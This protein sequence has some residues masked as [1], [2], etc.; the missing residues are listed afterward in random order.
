M[1]AYWV[2]IIAGGAV[3]R[4]VEAWRALAARAIES[5]L[6]FEPA[7]ALPALRLEP[8]RRTEFFLLWRAGAPPRLVLLW[9]MAAR[10]AAFW[11]QGWRHDYLCVGAPLLDRDEAEAALDAFLA[12]WAARPS[13]A[14]LIMGPLWPQGGF[15]R[16]LSVAAAQRGQGMSW[17]TREKRALL[18]LRKPPQP[19]SAKR[20]KEWARLRRRLDEK[21]PL[22]M[23]IDAETEEIAC[24][25]DQFLELEACG[26]KGRDGGALARRRG[27]A[28]FLREM[29][30]ALAREQNC[31]LFRLTSGE[32]TLACHILLGDTR[33]GYFW[34]TAYDEAF[35]KFSPG[36]LLTLDMTAELHRDSWRSSIDSCARPDHSMI[37]KLWLDRRRFGEIALATRPGSGFFLRALIFYQQWRRI[38]RER[39]KAMA[40][41]CFRRGKRSSF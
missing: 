2:E 36:V 6:F 17:I 4:H 26:W 13:L 20:R 22:R 27:H 19:A 29:G 30:M 18:D 28:A 39:A 1:A 8:N 38:L 21:S 3:E 14:A 31:R 16:A 41:Q 35:E 37:D 24:G 32:R 5:N 10:R 33:Q 11:R 34:K 40:T 9:P 15:Y 23:R 12:F 7:F 25:L